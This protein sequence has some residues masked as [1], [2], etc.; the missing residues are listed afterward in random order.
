MQPLPR[1]RQRLYA[2]TMDEYSTARGWAD[3]AMAQLHED[4]AQALAAFQRVEAAHQQ[5]DPAPELVA[6][7]R[8]TAEQVHVDAES[9]HAAYEGVRRALAQ[10]AEAERH[11]R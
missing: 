10:D 4:F 6:A 9:A 11:P 1:R 3:A 7:F 8:G 2:A 5:G